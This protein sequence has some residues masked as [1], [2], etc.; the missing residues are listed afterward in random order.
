MNKEELKG[1]FFEKLYNCYPV[2]HDNFP[3]R[4]FWYYDDKYIRKVKL[5]KISNKK[6]YPPNKVSGVCLF[7]QDLKK[8]ILLCNYNNIWLYLYKN[9]SDDY[10]D[11]QELIKSWLEE[12]SRMNVYTPH[13]IVV[14]NAQMLE[15]SRM[16]VYT[17]MILFSLL[18]NALEEESRMNVYTPMFYNTFQYD[19]LDEGVKKKLYIPNGW[20]MI[21]EEKLDEGT[22]MNVNIPSA[23]ILLRYGML[24]EESKEN[25]VFKKMN[26]YTPVNLHITAPFKLD[27]ESQIT[28]ICI[29]CDGIKILEE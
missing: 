7:E 20:R 13:L 5:N 3:D 11:V 4:L 17:P 15:E 22:K 14:P 24:G 6:V 18:K 10:S 12:E 28:V 27:E 29:P 19:W 26:V 23:K 1:W 16:N 8:L 25:L 21:C 9:Y 2:K